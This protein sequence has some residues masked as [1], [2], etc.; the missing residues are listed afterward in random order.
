MPFPAGGAGRCADQGKFPV[1]IGAGAVDI[2]CAVKTDDRGAKTCGKVQGAGIGRDNHIGCGQ[3]AHKLT[4]SH[5]AD[6][7]DHLGAY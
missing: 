4:Q 6:A 2:G 5:V 7:V 3:G 1:Q